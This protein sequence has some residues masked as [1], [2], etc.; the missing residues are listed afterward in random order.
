MA[1]RPTW[2]M[3]GLI[4][5]MAIVTAV[6]VT[7]LQNAIAGNSHVAITGGVVGAVSGHSQVRA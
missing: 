1:D 3:M 5:L 2:R 4:I 7:L 6:V